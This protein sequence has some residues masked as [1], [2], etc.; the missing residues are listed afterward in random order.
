MRKKKK[1][2][3]DEIISDLKVQ[4]E[5]N[6]TLVKSFRALIERLLQENAQLKAKLNEFAPSVTQDQKL[7]SAVQE[8]L[9]T[10]TTKTATTK[11]PSLTESTS[12]VDE[13]QIE[14]T[15]SSKL[16]GMPSLES[17]L[18]S[19]EKSE[20]EE[21]LESSDEESAS[22]TSTSTTEEE[23]ES[24]GEEEE[25]EINRITNTET[26]KLRQSTNEVNNFDTPEIP[27]PIIDTNITSITQTDP[28]PS[29][30]VN[31]PSP[32]LISP[33][34]IIQ[35]EKATQIGR[36]KSTLRSLPEIPKNSSNDLP[37]QKS[38]YVLGQNR[39]PTTNH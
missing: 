7:S 36:N 25:E 16:I 28:S 30:S 18:M 35:E 19:Q 29:S 38:K 15:E 31:L 11:R 17:F 9:V 21:S 1:R 32:A 4:L 37:N 27:I 23:Q 5:E 13:E 6:V 24:E 26:N 22:S 14:V 8:A 3:K 34:L 12:N 10:A 2:D 39:N 33:R 20:A